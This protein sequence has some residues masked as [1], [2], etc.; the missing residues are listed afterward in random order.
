MKIT[1]DAGEPDTPPL[2]RRIAAEVRP[3]LAVHGTGAALVTGSIV[4]ARRGWGLLS[5]HLDGWERVG[6]LAAAGYV[7]VYTAGQ[8]PAITQFAAPGAVITWCVAAWCVAPIPTRPDPD[9]QPDDTEQPRGTSPSTPWPQSSAGP[10]QTGREPT[11]P[12]SSR[13]LSSAAGSSPH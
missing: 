3:V 8:Y 9:P 2:A 7:T 12:T 10:P 6:A 5:A 11:S 13:S 1:K 4:L